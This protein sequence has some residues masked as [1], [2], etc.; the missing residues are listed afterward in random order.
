MAGRSG[1]EERGVGEVPAVA[2]GAE[3][4]AEVGGPV[5]AGTAAEAEVADAEGVALGVGALA[6]EQTAGEGG[7]ERR[8]AEQREVDVGEGV[9]LHAPMLDAGEAACQRTGR[10]GTSAGT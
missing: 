1:V 3:V 7:K 4:D 9:G 5:A 8:R 6:A 10:P 2:G